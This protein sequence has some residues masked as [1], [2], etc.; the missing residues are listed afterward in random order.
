MIKYSF[1]NAH[2]LRGPVAR[3]L[4]LVAI[5]RLEP[6]SDNTFY[7]NKIEEQAIEIDTVIK[8]INIDLEGSSTDEK[9]F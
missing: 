9:L 7:F 5:K 6:H 8:Q 2:H 4:G 3:L 1:T